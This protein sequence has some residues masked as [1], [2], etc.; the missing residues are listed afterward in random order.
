MNEN[1]ERPNKM[2]RLK[3]L[4]YGTEWM[5]SDKLAEILKECFFTVK[6][7][8]SL[9]TPRDL[10]KFAFDKYV[11][12]ALSQGEKL[13]TTVVGRIFT[14]L[15]V[16][17]FEKYRVVQ[18]VRAT[19]TLFEV[20]MRNGAILLGLVGFDERENLAI[21]MGFDV[22][23]GEMSV[24]ATRVEWKEEGGK[25]VASRFMEANLSAEQVAAFLGKFGFMLKIDPGWRV[26]VP[27]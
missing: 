11:F 26:A 9:K 20:L 19:D 1:G 5:F 10:V 3:K 27:N 22:K 13:V 23:G 14:H 24:R 6:V 2:E 18:Q 17:N 16:V 4:H 8:G 21:G 12:P 25:K 15:V 7:G